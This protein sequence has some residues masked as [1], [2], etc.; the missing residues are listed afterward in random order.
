[1]SYTIS[2]FLIYQITKSDTWSHV[3]CIVRLVIVYD[4]L[5]ILA[6]RFWYDAFM[7]WTIC[8]CVRKKCRLLCCVLL[9]CNHDW[10]TLCNWSSQFTSN[11]VLYSYMENSEPKHHICYT[12]QENGDSCL[13]LLLSELTFNSYSASHDNWCTGTLWNRIITA[14][15][16]GMGEVGSARYEPALLPPC[17]SIRVLSYSNCQEIHSCQQT[18]LAV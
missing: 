1:M 7:L 18:G 16:E 14:Q 6:Y 4:H 9:V 17:P 10:G 8:L 5:Y 15:C 12:G 3:K 2:Y 11:V 13:K